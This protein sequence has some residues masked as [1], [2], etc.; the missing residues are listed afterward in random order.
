MSRTSPGRCGPASAFNDLLAAPATALAA[1]LLLT[2]PYWIS[3]IFKAADFSGAVA[4]TAA[5][6]V[7]LPALAALMTVAVQLLGS[8]AV[9]ANRAAW[10][11]AGALGVFT[12]VATLIAHRFW[13]AAPEAA[14]RELATFTEHVGL[15]GGLMLAAILATREKER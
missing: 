7:P 3:G 5:L 6:G 12:L 11:G 2:S 9:V 14:P 10:L 1:R 13:A 4:E 15:I 8:A